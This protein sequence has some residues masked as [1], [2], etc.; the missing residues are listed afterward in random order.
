MLS[1]LLLIILLS[2]GVSDIKIIIS[3]LQSV[4]ESVLQTFSFLVIINYIVL[5]Y[6]VI[7]WYNNIIKSHI[8]GVSH[9][10]SYY[11]FGQVSSHSV[12]RR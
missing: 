5:L 7:M 1:G 4:Q 9:V 10:R 3:S 11:R 2:L 12:S 8:L 6:P